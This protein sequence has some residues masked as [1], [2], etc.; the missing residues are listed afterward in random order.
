MQKH[1][2][3][4]SRFVHIVK[5]KISKNGNDCDMFLNPIDNK[6]KVCKLLH[7]S[8]KYLFT[9]YDLKEIINTSLS[10]EEYGFINISSIK[11]PYD[12]VPFSQYNLYNIYF[13]LNFLIT[14]LP[15]YL[16]CI[17]CI[18]LIYL[19]LNKIMNTIFAII[20]LNIYYLEKI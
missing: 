13:S 2:L 9:L 5:H 4:L 7:N 6:T 11:N 17:L 3:A 14:T 15:I 8:K 18:I 16:I 20:I 1:Y 10:R 12:N 19:I